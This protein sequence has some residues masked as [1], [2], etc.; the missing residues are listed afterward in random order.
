MDERW[1][2]EAQEI[3]AALRDLLEGE[4][5][6]TRVRKAEASTD[7]RD[8]ALETALEAF[9]LWE[10]P[11]DPAVL[12]RMAFEIGRS[13][14]PIAFV[15]TVPAQRFLGLPSTAYGAEG[16]VPAQAE[17]VLVKHA[18]GLAVQVLE[19][20]ARRSSA[21]DFL[22]SPRPRPNAECVADAAVARR[23]ARLIRLLDAARLVGAG[24]ALLDIGVDYAKE[25]RQSGR[26]IGAYQAVSHPLVN[27][28]IALEGAEL[29]LRKAAYTATPEA[30]GDGAHSPEFA[31]MVR[32]KAVQAA[33]FTAKIVHQ[34]MGGYG[35]ALDYDCQL[36]ARRIASWSR[37]LGRPEKDL[38]D[39]GRRLLDPATRADVAH[40]WHHR[41]GLP[42]PRWAA[43]AD[44]Y[45]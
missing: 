39:L 9:G 26:A 7:G 45:V 1:T 38:A 34:A 19:G 3:G 33:R 12:A 22:V 5:P 20:P 27:A 15:E 36:Y 30:G 8:H 21:G 14:A 13:L 32:A 29:L 11:N 41:Q 35:V 24:H 10:A 4:C 25:R 28:S 23:I 6:R 43:E 40:L 16:D 37:R 2:D 31:W 44:G 18:A 42:L 17:R